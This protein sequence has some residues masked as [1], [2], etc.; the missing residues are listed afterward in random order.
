MLQKE[1]VDSN[2]LALIK[3]LQSKEYLKNFNLA[4]GTALALYIGHRKSNDIDLF[5]DKDFDEQSVLEKLESGFNFILDYQEKNTLK[6]FIGEIKVD[7]LSHKYNTV[8]TSVKIDNIILASTEDIIA[9][10]LNAISGDGTRI[11]DFIDLYYLLK[12][13]SVDELLAC[14]EKK[15]NQRNLMQVIKS[16]NYYDEV[17]L[18]DWPV[19]IKDKDLSWDAI[20]KS[21]NAAMIVYTNSLLQPDTK[22]I[23][24]SKNTNDTKSK[25]KY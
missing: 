13:H 15:Y 24:K 12:E 17:N 6:G 21:I 7:I 4:G 8:A 18:D 16:L 11:K 19:L 25:M 14:Y 23:D 20:K 10:K 3:E 5:T 22:K 2:T 9:M 1:A